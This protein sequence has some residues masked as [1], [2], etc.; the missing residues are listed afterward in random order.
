MIRDQFY[1]FF[2][3][4]RLVGDFE[5]VL[6]E[7]GINIA[8]RSELER[9]CLNITDLVEKHIKPHLRDENHDIR[10]YFRECLGLTD[11]IT[12]I[13]KSSKHPNFQ[14]LLP[15]LEKLN[16]NNPIQNTKTSV[17]DQYNNKL[18]ELYIATLCLNL[19]GSSIA[20]DDPDYSVG[21]NPDILVE[22]NGKLWGFGCK[23]LHS[24]QPMTIFENIEKAVD[25]IEKSIADVG[26]PIINI[27][28]IM[29]H[30]TFWPELTEDGSTVKEFGAFTD[31]NFP[32]TKIINFC[33][34]IQKDIV[35]HVG[36]DNVH[37]VFVG[38]KSFPV[39]LL[40]SS[41]A[42]SIS[43]AGQPYPTRLNLFNIIAFGDVDNYCLEVC[44][45]LNHELQIIEY[46]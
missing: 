24:K 16:D 13:V 28:N 6:K 8:S 42:T 32:L 37:S 15:Y 31:I 11:L 38:K 10:P 27:K 18:F 29:D 2:D 41:T 34:Q 21:D 3:A 30:D 43:K 44:E 9:L 23:T 14:T 1:T 40:Y 35:D 20:I 4:E 7:N 36:Q 17:L 19:N 26:V 5:N 12:K 25:Q 39:V 22:I 45:K 33:S 46:E